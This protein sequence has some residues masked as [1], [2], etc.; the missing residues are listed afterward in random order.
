M[1]IFTAGHAVPGDTTIL[2][3]K[4]A[5]RGFLQDNKDNGTGRGERSMLM[6]TVIAI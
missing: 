1:K 5:V 4:Q 6:A 3:F 2:S